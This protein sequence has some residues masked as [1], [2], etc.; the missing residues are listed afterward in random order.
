VVKLG[1]RVAIP[2]DQISDWLYLKRGKMVG[3]ETVRVLMKH[4]SPEEAKRIK[5]M[6]LKP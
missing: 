2:E 1:Q 4:S 3:N 6:F 5:E